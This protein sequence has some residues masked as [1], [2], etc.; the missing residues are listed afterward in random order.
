MSSQYPLFLQIKLLL[1]KTRIAGISKFSTQ[2]WELTDI[3]GETQL[4]TDPRH[5]FAHALSL[6]CPVHGCTVRNF[7]RSGLGGG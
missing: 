1:V 6:C 4:D 2:K 3:L 5:A 7:Q